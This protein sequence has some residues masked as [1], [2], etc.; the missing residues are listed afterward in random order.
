MTA[1]AWKQYKEY[2][3]GQNELRPITKQGFRGA[4]GGDLGVTI[5]DGL[6]TL[7]IMN[8][9]EQYQEGRNW[10]AEHFTLENKVRDTLWFGRVIFQLYL[11]STLNC[12]CLRLRFGSWVVF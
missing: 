7:Y 2:A 3:W 6:D 9:T 1:H 12:L 10:V 5:I 11:C 8:L 4:F